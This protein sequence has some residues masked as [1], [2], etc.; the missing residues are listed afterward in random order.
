MSLGTLGSI[1]LGAGENSLTQTASNT[2][3]FSQS[4]VGAILAQL[5]S[6]SFN[7]SQTAVANTIRSRDASNTLTLT[8]IANKVLPTSASNTLTFSQVSVAVKLKIVSANNALTLTQLATANGTFSKSIFQT[9]LFNQTLQRTISR[10]IGPSNTFSMGNVVTGYAAKAAKNTLTFSQS[11]TAFI[12]KKA[13][14]FLELTQTVGLTTVLNRPV[15]STFELLGRATTGPNTFRRTLSNIFSPFD[16]AVGFA[17]KG[18]ANTLVLSQTLTGFAAKKAANIFPVFDQATYNAVFN[19]TGRPSQCRL[20]LVQSATVRLIKNVSAS[21]SLSMV[22][23]ATK[24]KV[25]F[26]SA[27]NTFAMT[28]DLVRMR[29]HASAANTLTISQTATKSKIAYPKATSLYS[30][31]Q[32]LTRTVVFN[33]SASNVLQFPQSRQQLVNIGGTSFITVNNAVGILVQRFV[34]LQGLNRT[35]M[36]PRPEFDDSES[37]GG[38]MVILRSKTGVRRI[39][40]KDTNKASLNYTFIIDRAKK[41]ELMQFIRVYSSTPF[42]LENHKAERWFVTFKSNP[43]SFTE[44]ALYEDCGRITINLEFEGVRLV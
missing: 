38:S 9:I 41:N 10:L 5:S 23:L 28:Q 12:A 14:N 27:S 25:L 20:N 4:A 39:Y 31:Q 13:T 16:V 22:Q 40:K 37:F 17:V 30:P 3:N 29:H 33:R 2:L 26:A 8:Q 35:V 6:N 1:V 42:Y 32:T 36:L 18:G 15:F 19:V 24:R 21:N 44:E 7:L 34:L 43:F 11:A